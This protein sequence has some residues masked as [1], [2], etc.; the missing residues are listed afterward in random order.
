MI[1]SACLELKNH[2]CHA[3]PC[4]NDRKQDCKGLHAH[5]LK[6]HVNLPLVECCGSQRNFP[7]G[8]DDTILGR[9]WN[10][11][12]SYV[13]SRFEKDPDLRTVLTRSTVWS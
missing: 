3:G 7:D 9:H 8:G 4:R 5:V 6:L 10:L 1:D 2:A 12:R 11:Q 13:F